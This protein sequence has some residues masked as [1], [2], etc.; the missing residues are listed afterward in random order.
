M[1][2]FFTV[3]TASFAVAYLTELIS[4]VIPT[5]FQTFAKHIL[6]IALAVAVSWVIW[7]QVY[8]WAMFIAAIGFVSTTCRILVDR[9][10]SKPQ[11]IS[12]YTRR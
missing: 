6:T 1:N 4:L 10:T 12:N 11:V 2:D 5:P 7:S 3:I 8:Y 9:V